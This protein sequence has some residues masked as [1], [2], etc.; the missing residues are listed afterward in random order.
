MASIVG[1]SVFEMVLLCDGRLVPAD[2]FLCD[3]AQGASSLDGIVKVEPC[4]AE[5]T[6]YLMPRALVCVLETRC[7]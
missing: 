3:L 6:Y 4:S 1:D 5:S 7:L 2:M